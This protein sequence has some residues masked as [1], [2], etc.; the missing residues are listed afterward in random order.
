MYVERDKRRES[1]PRARGSLPLAYDARVPPSRALVRQIRDY[2]RG[3]T[4]GTIILGPKNPR[5]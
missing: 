2:T 3:K 5:S 1:K 4:R